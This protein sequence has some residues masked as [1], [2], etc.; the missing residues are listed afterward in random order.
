M[1]QEVRNILQ[2]QT[3]SQ[4]QLT[5]ACARLNGRL[6]LTNPKTIA[7]ELL[8]FENEIDSRARTIDRYNQQITVNGDLNL[9]DTKLFT[10]LRDEFNPTVF[11]NDQTC[12]H[13]FFDEKFGNTWIEF[14]SIDNEFKNV[15]INI[16]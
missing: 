3:I 13:W 12:Q 15:V 6:A 9:L 11:H 16:F 2:D 5:C 1:L 8:L 14:V 10:Y 4:R 7:N